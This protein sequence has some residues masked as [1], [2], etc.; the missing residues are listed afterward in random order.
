MAAKSHLEDRHVRRLFD[1]TE[2]EVALRVELGASA[3]ALT[4]RRPLTARARP[5]YPHNRR[6]D[7]DLEL[8]CRPPGWHSPERRIQSHDHADP[9]FKP[10]PCSPPSQKRRTRTVRASWESLQES[11]KPE[12]ALMLASQPT[13]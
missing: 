4:A 9:G 10:A 13:T 8:G 5:T 11:E 3:A 6:G 1:Q 7:P 2:Q 12:C